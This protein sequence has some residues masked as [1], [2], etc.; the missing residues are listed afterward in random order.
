MAKSETTNSRKVLVEATGS[1]AAATA[2]LLFKTIV[3]E[4]VSEKNTCCAALSGGTTPHGLY[5]SLVSSATTGEVPWECVE[6]FF[7]DERDVPQDHT[8]S[9]YRMVQRT[10]LDHVP[11]DPR[12]VHPMPADRVQLESAAAEYEQ[13]IR[14]VVPAGDDG[15]ARFDLILL[16]MGHEGHVASLFPR[17]PAVDEQEKLVVAHHVSTLG[18]WRMTF[19]FPLINA[20]RNVLML[21][22]GEDKAQAVADIL[23]N[24]PARSELLPAARIAPRNG[25]LIMVLDAAAARLSGLRPGSEPDAGQP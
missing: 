24:D 23:S 15:I 7:G 2:G 22:T 14:S 3:C 19:T 25:T 5:Q 11:I 21:V 17:T 6:L 10:M 13:L 20:A 4:A 12:R 9:N 8:D 16:G 1:Q 18:R